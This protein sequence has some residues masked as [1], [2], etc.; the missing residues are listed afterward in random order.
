MKIS[1]SRNCTSRAT[2]VI[3]VVTIAPRKLSDGGRESV[4]LRKD[5]VSGNIRQPPFTVLKPGRSA[6]LRAT[7]ADLKYAKHCRKS[8]GKLRSIWDPKASKLQQAAWLPQRRICFEA[9][10]RFPTK[11]GLRAFCAPP[12]NTRGSTFH[13]PFSKPLHK[14]SRD[15]ELSRPSRR[16]CGRH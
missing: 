12:A 6:D 13:L 2:I 1:G 16:F 7:F 10:T 5:C 9:R 3:N 11:F 15:L 14:L 4:F 8:C